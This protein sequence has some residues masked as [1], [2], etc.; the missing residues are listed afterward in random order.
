M[1]LCGTLDDRFGEMHPTALGPRLAARMSSCSQQ[2]RDG[3]IRRSAAILSRSPAPREGP[4]L[5]PN[6]SFVDSGVSNARAC[7]LH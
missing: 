2:R 1:K 4:S 5:W 3:V 6:G 7:I